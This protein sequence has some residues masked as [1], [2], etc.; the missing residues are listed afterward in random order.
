MI[1]RAVL[2]AQFLSSFALRFVERQKRRPSTECLLCRQPYFLT[3]EMR[4]ATKSQASMSVLT[5]AVES[6][7]GKPPRMSRP[8]SPNFIA[9]WPS[10]TRKV[11]PLLECFLS[12]PTSGPHEWVAFVNGSKNR[13][14]RAY[15][16]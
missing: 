13:H 8:L 4:R 12:L 15:R 14:N 6:T 5:S 1:F 3:F 16:P 7:G 9:K 10:G 2:V 11:V